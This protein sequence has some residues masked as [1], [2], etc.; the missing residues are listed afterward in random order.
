M[1]VIKEFEIE[2]NMPL[3]DSFVGPEEHF[4]GFSVEKCGELASYTCHGET[5][6]EYTQQDILNKITPSKDT[7]FTG[8]PNTFLL[9]LAFVRRQVQEMD[10]NSSGAQR[11][12]ANNGN[13]YSLSTYFKLGTKTPKQPRVDGTVTG[14]FWNVS[15]KL[16]YK[17]TG[18]EVEY[19]DTAF[20]ETPEKA[21]HETLDRLFRKEPQ[22]LDNF[23]IVQPVSVTKYCPESPETDTG[24]EPVQLRF[25][26]TV[27]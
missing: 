11:Y 25:D 18:K 2:I 17:T 9:Y 3:K 7:D 14:F 6:T 16:Q 15:V 8:I 1:N 5:N 20:C 10:M 21:V 27:N 24:Y 23:T 13:G 19:T 12:Y 22:L 4:L 26:Y